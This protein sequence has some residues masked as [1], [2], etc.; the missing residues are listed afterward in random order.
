MVAKT[1]RW[2]EKSAPWIKP[3]RVPEWI[4]HWHSI[5]GGSIGGFFGQ[6]FFRHKTKSEKFRPVFLRTIVI[7]VILLIVISVMNTSF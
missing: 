2:F 3:P 5:F 7:Q 4:L 1:A 6:R